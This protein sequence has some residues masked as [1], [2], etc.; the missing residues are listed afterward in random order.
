MAVQR[1]RKPGRPARGYRLSP[2][3]IEKIERVS[4]ALGMTQ[5][6]YLSMV[7]LESGQEHTAY[8]AQ[9]AAVEAFVASG[10]VTAL[11]S[12]VLSAAEAAA[13]RDEGA[14]LAEELFGRPLRRPEEV[15]VQSGDGDPRVRALFAAFGAG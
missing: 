9:Q 14:Q 5:S 6:D 10:L 13:I 15:G 11:A 1:R 12:K 3:A 7:V 8:F 4:A 2:E